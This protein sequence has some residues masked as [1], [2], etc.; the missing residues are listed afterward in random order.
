MSKCA[1]GVKRKGVCFDTETIK[2][3]IEKV[4]KVRVPKSRKACITLV[5]G[6]MKKKYGC[7]DETCWDKHSSIFRKV[8]KKTHKPDARWT[9]RDPAV[10]NYDLFN[11]MRQYADLDPN[12][13][14]LGDWDFD[15]YH[16]KK[17][18]ARL[19]KKLDETTDVPYRGMVFSFW[20]KKLKLFRHWTCVVFDKKKGVIQFFDSNGDIKVRLG[21]VPTI[22]VLKS[23][24]GDEYTHYVYNVFVAQLDPNNC[25]IFCVDFII[26]MKNGVSYET[27]IKRLIRLQKKLQKE[28]YNDYITGIRAKYFIVDYEL[29]EVEG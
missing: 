20:G 16:F 25:G 2:H 27:Y 17:D 22:D 10:S 11:I 21:I 15:I 3:Y 6:Y 14:Y 18:I 9:E 12:F 29:P 13:S 5:K 4:M 7:D 23:L 19:K 8:I 1:P 28:E 24:V 26:N